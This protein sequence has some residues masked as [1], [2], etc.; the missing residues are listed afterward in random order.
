MKIVSRDQ[1]LKEKEEKKK[2]EMEKQAEKERKKQEQIALQKAKD[3][4]R[5]IPPSEMFKQE[6]DKYSQFDD[7][8]TTCLKY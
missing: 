3:E 1:L 8:V 5:K 6:T 2:I 7:K 4:Q